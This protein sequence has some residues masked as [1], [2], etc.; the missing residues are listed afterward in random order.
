ME[1]VL[2]L[3]IGV[4]IGFFVRGFAKPDIIG[5]LRLDRSDPDSPYLFLEMEPDSMQ[6]IEHRKYVTMEVMIK[7]YISRD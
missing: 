5:I 3:A 7:N 6:K 1:F 2:V 4:L